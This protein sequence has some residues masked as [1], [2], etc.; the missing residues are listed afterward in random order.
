MSR[1]LKISSMLAVAAM[2]ATALLTSL[3]HSD[4]TVH[5]AEQAANQQP[6]AQSVPLS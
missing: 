2:A 4:R 3:G 1:Q 5:V 6:M